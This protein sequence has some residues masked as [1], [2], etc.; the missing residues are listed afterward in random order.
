MKK[1]FLSFLM[2]LSLV[3]VT[4][5][6]T[7]AKEQLPNAEVILNTYNLGFLDSAYTNYCTATQSH[8]NIRVS[9][10]SGGVSAM[11]QYR[12]PNQDWQWVGNTYTSIYDSYTFNMNAVKGNDYRLHIKTSG[13][14]ATGQIL[15][16]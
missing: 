5:N 3:F 13:F 6:V 2:A 11:L 10:T 8:I 7:F 15:C 1:M 16:W 4:T 9:N 14:S 12:G